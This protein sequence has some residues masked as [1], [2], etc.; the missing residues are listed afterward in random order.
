[1]DEVCVTHSFLLPLIYLT[2]RYKPF[3]FLSSYVINF[4][5]LYA[6]I[7]KYIQH[8]LFHHNMYTYLLVQLIDFVRYIILKKK[9][10]MYSTAFIQHRLF[11]SQRKGK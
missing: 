2:R 7:Y 10:R 8:S 11:D 3:F 6:C 9:I 5:R 1:M 4:C